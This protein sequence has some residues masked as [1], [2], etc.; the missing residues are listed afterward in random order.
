M[1]ISPMKKERAHVSMGEKL[2]SA[3]KEYAEGLEMD[4][5]EFVSALIRDELTNRRLLPAE[6]FMEGN[7][8]P[9]PHSGVDLSSILNP[10]AGGSKPRHVRY[11]TAREAARSS[12]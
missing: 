11:Q 6:K 12:K 4:F 2:L 7:S 9:Q 8:A 10:S 1:H 3:A 5:S